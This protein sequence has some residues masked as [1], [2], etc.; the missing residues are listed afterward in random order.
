[1]GTPQYKRVLLKLSGEQLAGKYE[2]GVDPEIVAFLAAEVK[3]VV[4]SGCQV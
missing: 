4:E 2:F 3:K 1:M